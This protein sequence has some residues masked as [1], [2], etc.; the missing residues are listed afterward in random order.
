MALLDPHL[1]DRI[2][3]DFDRCGLVGE[4]TNKLV[5]YLQDAGW[6]D[7]CAARQ[8]SRRLP[9]PAVL[10]PAYAFRPILR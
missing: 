2:L 10:D 1:I 5:G 9:A 3:G 8:R 4:E 6:T 7:D